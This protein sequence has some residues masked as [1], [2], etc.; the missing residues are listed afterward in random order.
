MHISHCNNCWNSRGTQKCNLHSRVTEIHGIPLSHTNFVNKT[1]VLHFSCL[2]NLLSREICKLLSAFFYNPCRNQH[3]YF[4]SLS[5][6]NELDNRI[7][8]PAGLGDLLY[9][10]EDGC[11]SVLRPWKGTTDNPD[12]VNQDNPEA[13]DI[14]IP[15]VNRPGNTRPDPT[16][17]YCQYHKCS[18]NRLAIP[19]HPLSY[20]TL[21]EH[22]TKMYS[23]IPQRP[24]LLR[25]RPIHLPGTQLATAPGPAPSGPSKPSTDTTKPSISTTARIAQLLGACMLEIV[26][27]SGL[28]I[29]L[30]IQHY[31]VMRSEYRFQ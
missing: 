15:S 5:W 11:Y 10:E 9:E 6:F 7:G 2:P 1:L 25:S 14:P 30:L 20:L 19:L 8:L 13:P 12:D 22:H 21:T 31:K 17:I 3:S 28:K 18:G 26:G 24:P 4:Q 29:L 27:S 23:T 16:L